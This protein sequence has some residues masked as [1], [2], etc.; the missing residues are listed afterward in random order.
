MILLELSGSSIGRRAWS[1]TI[2]FWNSGPLNG[3]LLL[4]VFLS[5]VFV[6]LGCGRDPKAD[7]TTELAASF[8]DSPA[9]ED[10]I[11]ANTAFEQ[12]RYKESLQLLHKVVSRGD[13]TERQRKA[14][15][16]LVGQVLQAVHDDP[17]LSADPQIHRLMELLILRTMGEP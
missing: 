11:K 17:K 16:G 4:M 12:G 1:A 10:A 5:T 13:L 15:S 14:I 6:P 7:A 3:F 2:D 8:E 9:R